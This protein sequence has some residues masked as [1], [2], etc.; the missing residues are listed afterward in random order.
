MST[1]H[2][3][4][5]LAVLVSSLTP[6]LASAQGASPEAQAPAESGIQAPGQEQEG[7]VDMRGATAQFDYDRGDQLFWG[8]VGSIAGLATFLVVA[9]GG[10]VVSPLLC[11]EGQEDIPCRSAINAT[12]GIVGF[13]GWY[14]V[15]VIFVNFTGGSRSDG[16][17]QTGAIMGVLSGALASSVLAGVMLDV[18]ELDDVQTAGQQFVGWTSNVVISALPGVI[19]ALGYQLFYPGPEQL[20][21]APVFYPEGGAG[22]GVGFRF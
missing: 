17:T 14:A 1:N 21:L 11:G 12:T 8:G 3:L 13:I 6:G 20:T 9:G 15:P 19:S 18:F 7:T 16:W 5:T 2:L 4:T 22:V 10:S